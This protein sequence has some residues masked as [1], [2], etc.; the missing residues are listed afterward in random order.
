MDDIRTAAQQA[1]TGLA[2]VP[3]G[4]D[5]PEI[6]AAIRAICKKYPG[7]YWRKLEDIH[8]Y[9]EAFVQELSDG[10]YLGALIPEEYGGA[11]LP[12][13]AGGVILEEIHAAGCAA[14]ACHAQMYMMGTLLRHGSEAA[15]APLSAGDR[16][17]PAALP[18]LRRDRAHHRVRH[19]QAQDPRRC[20]RAT[21]TSCAGRRS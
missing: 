14:H 10:G 19:H 2:M 9:P 17:R 18:V 5:Y 15:E 3:L 20:A 6:R 8:A 21:T 4:E 11:G 12:L 7:A 16:R 13:R 1:G